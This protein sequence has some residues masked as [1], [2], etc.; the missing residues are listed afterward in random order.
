MR[1]RFSTFGPLRRYLPENRDSVELELPE[2][3]TAAELLDRLDSTWGE[4]GIILINGILADEDTRLCH[5][6]AVEV[7]APVG[8]GQEPARSAARADL[9]R[10][11]SPF[12]R[13]WLRLR[14]R[15]LRLYTDLRFQRHPDVS[16]VTDTVAVGRAFEPGQVPRLAAEG[17]SAVVD[18][19]EEAVDDAKLLIRHGILLLHL[20]STDGHAPSQDQLT[21]GVDWVRAQI[22]AGRK[23]LVHCAGGIGRSPLLVCAVLVREG[24][25]AQ[26]ALEKVRTRRWQ[27]A[28][29]D[30][31]LEALLAFE[32]HVRR[33]AGT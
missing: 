17:I 2:G 28:P 15:V 23:V 27:V 6:D 8:G 18:L 3:A 12:G 9:E 29:N 11:R 24:H 13:L 30:R 25:T 10:L 19:R 26:Q 20:P 33:D 1:V 21:Q 7:F 4:S 5:G 14:E 32:A 22:A 31:Q 16:W